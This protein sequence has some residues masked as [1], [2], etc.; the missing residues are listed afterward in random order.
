MEL[1]EPAEWFMVCSEGHWETHPVGAFDLTVED[2]DEMVANFEADGR[3]R[4]VIDYDHQSMAARNNRGP[5]PAAGWVI[6]LERRDGPKVAELWAKAEWTEKASNTL[7]NGEYLFVS[8]V[9]VFGHEDKRTGEGRGTRLFNVAITNNPFFDHLPAIAA[10][11]VPRSPM[12]RVLLLTALALPESTTDAELAETARTNKATQDRVN[13]ATEGRKA[14]GLEGL[15]LLEAE[16]AVGR[17]VLEH[18]A[19]AEITL[20]QGV[21]GAVAGLRP[22]LEHAGLVEAAELVKARKRLGELEAKGL[23]EAAEA[24]GKLVP[25]QREWFAGFAAN[26][27]A[28]AKQ[29]LASAPVVAS[30]AGSRKA[31]PKDGAP[32]EFSEADRSVMRRMGLTEEQFAKARAL[33]QGG[34]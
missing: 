31:P 27:P 2:L 16:A 14:G 28:G 32:T 6:A 20:D 8:P 7:K 29:W 19:C 5:V 10:D 22:V 4:I 24:A 15:A 11:E 1:R 25:A 34:A 33:Q 21:D 23:I 30:A 26:D 9:I 13:A 18:R 12:L 17:S 3:G